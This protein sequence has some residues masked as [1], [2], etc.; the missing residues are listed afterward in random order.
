M[1]QQWARLRIG[2]TRVSYTALT[3]STYPP[4]LPAYLQQCT[5]SPQLQWPPSHARYAHWLNGGTHS[6]LAPSPAAECS[7]VPS[8]A[9]QSSPQHLS[10]YLLPPHPHGGTAAHT[11]PHCTPLRSQQVSQWNLHLLVSIVPSPPLC[12]VTMHPSKQVMVTTSDDH[13]WKMW[14]LPR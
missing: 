13:T 12:S 4:S 6:E 3:S 14:A 11:H 9:S 5:L 1:R 10:A 8:R 2:W 7:G